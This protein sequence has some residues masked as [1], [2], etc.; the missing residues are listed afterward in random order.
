MCFS[1]VY[2]VFRCD[3]I[4]LFC[5]N[6]AEGDI[7]CDGCAQDMGQTTPNKAIQKIINKLKTK[8]P[9][10]ISAQNEG[11]LHEAEGG[12]VVITDIGTD[13]C[14]WSEMIKDWDEHKSQCPYLI[15]QCNVCK[16]HKCP[17]NKM[18]EH[19][20]HC[21]EVEILCPNKPKSCGVFIQIFI[22]ILCVMFMYILIYI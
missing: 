21:P 14:D 2:I 9:S 10:T 16:K 4:P 20:N 5:M 6:D 12:N 18:E 7:V 22:H 3:G 13:L 8:C 17:R 1:C 15:I 19:K 11:K